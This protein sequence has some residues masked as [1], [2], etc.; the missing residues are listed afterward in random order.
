MLGNGSNDAGADILDQWR[1]Y[2]REHKRS[3]SSDEI[4][5]E[6]KDPNDY[7][8]SIPAEADEGVE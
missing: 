7:L 3:A 2:L 1:E 8:P 6:S 4:G 5:P